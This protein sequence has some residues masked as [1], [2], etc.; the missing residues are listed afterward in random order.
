ML[1]SWPLGS[2]QRDIHSD[3]GISLTKAAPMHTDQV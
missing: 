3:E 1:E 2:S